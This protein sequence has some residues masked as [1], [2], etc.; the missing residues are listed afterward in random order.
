MNVMLRATGD[1]MLPE[2]KGLQSKLLLAGGI[3]AALCVVGF[4]IDP[5]QFVRS[6][7]P[8]YMWMLSITLGSL[9]LAM[10][11]QVS[12]GAWGVVIRRI[13]GAASRTLP[14]LTVLFIPIALSLRSLYPWADETHLA[15]DPILQWKQPYLNV[16]F[17]LA[18]AAF[19]FAVWNGIAYL[20]NKW[21]VEQD[22]T[23]DPTIPRKMQIL[24][25]G[26]LLAYGL[27]IT[28]ASFDWLM[29][30]EPHWFSTMYG[31]LIMGGQA[32][33]AMAFAIVVLSW[34]A[35]REPLHGLIS[36]NHFHDLG[37]LML[38]FTMLWT[39]FGFSQYLIIW[40]ANLPEETEWYIHRTGHGWQ[41]LAITLVVF[42]F[43]VPFLVLLSRA[44]KRQGSVLGRVAAGL[45]VMRF[46]DLF[47]L[48]AP[49]FAPEGGFHLHWLDILVPL[50][51]AAVWLGFFVYQLRGR[52]LLPL[53]DPEFTEALKHVRAA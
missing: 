12:G 11:H 10:V 22:A 44:V 33:S 5:A 13:L 34:L 41:I 31:V 42:H 39:Y 8:A 27:T 18:R 20:L 45:L 7:L 50:S 4:A 43:A 46:V 51:L 37:N 23:G 26:G 36:P 29:S 2:L 16:P 30:L 48:S 15:G 1:E 17:F 53:Y 35:R 19:Y 25:A 32:L 52:A 40:A 3:G 21:S 9:A 38:G 14:L 47:W 28:F 6:L 49:A 24:S